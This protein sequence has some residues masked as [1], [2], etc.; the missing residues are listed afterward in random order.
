MNQNFE[1]VS[2]NQNAQQ[3]ISSYLKNVK[4]ILLQSKDISII[5][6]ILKQISR[7]VKNQDE[8]SDQEEINKIIKVKKKGFF[9]N[10]KN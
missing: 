1:F 8:S 7:F 6:K 9:K 10:K 3:S 5:K 2:D 4:E